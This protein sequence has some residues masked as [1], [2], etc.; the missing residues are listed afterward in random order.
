MENPFEI[1]LEKLDR[2]ENAIEKLKMS[3]QN[4]DLDI[5]MEIEEVAK[6]INLSKVS[7]YGLTNRKQIPHYKV[8]KK[9]FF[10]KSEIDNWI[11]SKKVKTVDDIENEVMKYL[12]R[13]PRKF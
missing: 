13:N 11:N 3:N 12:A 7:I 9:L 8:G 5:N 2:I 6:Y 1:I 4:V 10:K